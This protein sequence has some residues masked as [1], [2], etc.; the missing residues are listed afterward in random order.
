MSCLRHRLSRLGRMAPPL[1]HPSCELKG[2]LPQPWD[3][4]AQAK[5]V[6]IA[7]VVSLRPSWW[8]V[9]RNLHS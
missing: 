1:L 8:V 7:R 4:W 9:L 3:P 6:Q 2:G 5:V